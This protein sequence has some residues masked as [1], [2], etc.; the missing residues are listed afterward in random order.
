LLPC[1][2]VRHERE[3]PPEP[4]GAIDLIFFLLLAAAIVFGLS[5][6]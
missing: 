5:Q 6:L 1:G 2:P 4:A 3:D